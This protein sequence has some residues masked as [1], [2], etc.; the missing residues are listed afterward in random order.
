MAESTLKRVVMSPA[1]KIRRARATSINRAVSAVIDVTR[2][3]NRGVSI[4]RKK[5]ISSP[6]STAICLAF[7]S[8][9]P[10][11]RLVKRGAT[12]K[13]GRRITGAM[14]KSED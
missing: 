10:K 14:S 13:R 1:Q 9:G 8:E 3:K 4:G 12:K 2:T 5:S 7:A 11:L 6:K